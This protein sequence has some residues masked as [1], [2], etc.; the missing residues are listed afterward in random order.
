[1]KTFEQHL[2][3]IFGTED[4]MRHIAP[5][6]SDNDLLRAVRDYAREVAQDALNRAAENAK[7]DIVQEPIDGYWTDVAFVDRDSITN[8]VI[9]TP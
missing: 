8:T 4:E 1:M 2:Q 6:L 9:N 5:M 7:A 3:E